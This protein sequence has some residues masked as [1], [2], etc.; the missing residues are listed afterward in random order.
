MIKN[1]ETRDSEK[2]RSSKRRML[3][4]SLICLL[5]MLV[6]WLTLVLQILQLFQ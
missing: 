6:S 2:W 5:G 4:I 3:I 1:E